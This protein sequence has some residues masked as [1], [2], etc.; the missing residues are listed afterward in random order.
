[1]NKPENVLWAEFMAAALQPV[2][3]GNWKNDNMSI[4]DIADAAANHADCALNEYYARYKRD[5]ERT[6]HECFNCTMTANDY[7]D[8]KEDQK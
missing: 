4:L 8:R 7:L 3:A 1:M 5:G 6:E 2:I